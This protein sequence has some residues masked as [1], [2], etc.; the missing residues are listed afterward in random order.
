MENPRVSANGF[1]GFRLLAIDTGLEL[2]IDGPLPPELPTARLSR[3][4]QYGDGIIGLLGEVRS[5]TNWFLPWYVDVGTGDTELTWMAT[6]A[7]A[8]ASAGATWWWAT[9]TWL[10]RSTVTRTSISTCPSAAPASERCS[11]SDGGVQAPRA[12]ASPRKFAPGERA[13]GGSRIPVAFR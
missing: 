8:T 12:G 5:G 1:L 9:G 4:G 13:E 3:N 2:G 10:T 6:A 7:S 11:A